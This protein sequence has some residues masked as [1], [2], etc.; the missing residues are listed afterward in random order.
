[1]QLH[2]SVKHV[3]RSKGRSSVAAAAYRLALKLEDERTGLVH[4]YTRKNGVEHSQTFAP[5]HAPEWVHDPAKLWNTVEQRERHVKA[6]TAHELELAFPHEFT[7]MQRREAGENISR[8]LVRR[9]GC[10]VSIAHHLPS[11]DGDERNYHA[12]LLFTTRGFDAS[13][14]DGWQ[15][16]KYRD[17]SQDTRDHEKK[18]CLD[19]NGNKTT[20]GRIELLELR[21]FS[22]GE[23]NRIAKRDR[24]NVYVQHLSFEKQGIDREPTQHMGHKAT[25]MERR[26]EVSRIG[27]KNREVEQL[28]AQRLKDRAVEAVLSAQVSMQK[29]A[30]NTWADEKRQTLNERL[31]NDQIDLHSKHRNE[32]DQLH[33]R[34][35][36]QNEGLRRTIASQLQTVT[37]RLD[38]TTGAR[39]IIRNL[40]GKTK[41]DRAT[42]HQLQKALQAV[43]VAEKVQRKELKQQ[44][45]RERDQFVERER[46]EGL[47]LERNIEQR[48]PHQMTLKERLKAEYQRATKQEPQNQRKQGRVRKIGI[49]RTPH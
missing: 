31:R 41:A 6:E 27:E 13:T 14:K 15:K 1:M 32:R 34:Q 30:L 2:A 29:D 9:Y 12:H 47:K 24:V 8:E 43:M 36:K 35:R 42:Q 48:E 40:L 10:A 16:T 20:R 28:N 11:P 25:S 18:P 3:K 7:P 46:E 22:A 39:R 33:D 21:E 17:L 38:T 45:Q 4:V 49:H 19:D 26:G 5:D 44:Q 37:R 23:M